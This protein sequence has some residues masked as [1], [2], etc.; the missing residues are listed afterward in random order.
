MAA[1]RKSDTSDSSKGFAQ[2]YLLLLVF[3]VSA[4][5]CHE[6]DLASFPTFEACDDQAVKYLANQAL[7]DDQGG[8]LADVLCRWVDK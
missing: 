3:C 8:K 4:T 7:Y 5:E 2:V 1:E 6:D